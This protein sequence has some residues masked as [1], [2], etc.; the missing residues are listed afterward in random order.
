METTTTNRPETSNLPTKTSTKWNST[1]PQTPTPRR[2]IP[3]STNNLPSKTETVIATL[4]S[5]HPTSNRHTKKS[6]SNQLSKTEITTV[7]LV[8][9]NLQNLPINSHHTKMTMITECPTKE[10]EETT[11]TTKPSRKLTDKTGS[12]SLST[13]PRN[14]SCADKDVEE[15]STLTASRNMKQSA[16]KSSRRKE[17]NLTLKS[18]DSWQMSK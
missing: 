6:M 4:D 3:K 11:S 18:T 1:I 17:K 13:I 12:I 10:E 8:N 7:T 14:W 15:S 16:E 5:N 9:I 2:N